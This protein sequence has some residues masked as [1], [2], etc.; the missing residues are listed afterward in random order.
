MVAVE[1]TCSTALRTPPMISGSALGSSTRQSTSPPRMPMPRPR[2]HGRI[3]VA[4]PGVGARQ[5]RGYG[6]H[7][8]RDEW[9]DDAQPE[10]GDQQDQHTE[11]GQR[12]Q[13]VGRP[14]DEEAAPAGVPDPGPDRQG[15]HE[16]D[17]HRKRDVAEVLDEPGRDAHPT[18]SSWRGRTASRSS[19]RGPPD[20]RADPRPRGERAP[21]QQ[22]QPVDGQREQQHEDD[23]GDVSAGMSRWKASVNILPRPPK[24]ITAPTVTRLIARHRRHPEPGEDHRDGHRQLDADEPAQ[25]AC[26]PSPWPS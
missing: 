26:T 19:S 25:R 1:I 23:A 18:P 9:A 6:E 20:G 15:D 22:D 24:P 17:D 3:D 8:Q 2:R 7:D 16:R 21:D 12:P 11:R 4:H 5:Q 10:R 13:R 14:D